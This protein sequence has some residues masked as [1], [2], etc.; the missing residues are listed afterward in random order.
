MEELPHGAYRIVLAQDASSLFCYIFVFV[1][2]T[3][4]DN[5]YAVVSGTV[6]VV[7]FSHLIYY[8]HA[9]EKTYGNPTKNSIF[10]I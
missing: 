7:V 2:S 9:I 1:K 8:V 4:N 5:T 10:V 6:V 3:D